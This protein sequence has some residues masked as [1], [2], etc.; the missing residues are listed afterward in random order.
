VHHRRFLVQQ[1]V[2]RARGI[3][4]RALADWDTAEKPLW[5][6]ASAME[7]LF[8]DVVPM[9]DPTAEAEAKAFFIPDPAG[10]TVP[11]TR[12][13]SKIQATPAGF[14]ATRPPKDRNMSS[15]AARSRSPNRPAKRS[16]TT[17]APSGADATDT[18]DATGPRTS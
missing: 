1:L 4:H 8:P 5:E 9:P 15:P 14:A 2:D 18:R 11:P 13:S 16:R 7:R 12:I 10:E 3:A 6:L 17:T